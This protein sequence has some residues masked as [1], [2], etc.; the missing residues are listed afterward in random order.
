MYVVAPRL[1]RETMKCLEFTTTLPNETLDFSVSNHSVELPF[2]TA[3]SLTDKK[4]SVT[5]G[6]AGDILVIEPQVQMVVKNRIVHLDVHPLLYKHGRP[7]FKRI[8][9]HGE[10]PILTVTWECF[11]DY[12]L[13]D[14]PYL[15]DIYIID[16]HV[17]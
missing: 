16:E 9:R 7:S 1:Y 6:E 12:D 17:R 14:L 15:Y 8:W 3:R 13:M 2:G 5:L 10:K 11:E 4:K